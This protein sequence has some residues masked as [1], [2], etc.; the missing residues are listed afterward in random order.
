MRRAFLHR[1]APVARRNPSMTCA[2]SSSGSVDSLALTYSF[3]GR[4]Q[5]DL[6]AR[7]RDTLYRYPSLR[8]YHEPVRLSDLRRAS[9][10]TARRRLHACCS[11][12]GSGP[13]PRLPLRVEEDR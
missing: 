6:F 10:D 8:T 13:R 5:T 4:A 12:R 3:G 2:S 11:S 9:A 1:Y 7:D